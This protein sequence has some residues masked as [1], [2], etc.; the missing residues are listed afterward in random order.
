MRYI[1]KKL[2]S[3]SKL[4]S[5]DDP[6]V[7]KHGTVKHRQL[8][9]PAYRSDWTADSFL[10]ETGSKEVVGKTF[11]LNGLRVVF[12]VV[13]VLLLFLLIRVAWLQIVRGDYYYDL[14]EGNRIRISNLEP[15]RGI[16]YD[17]NLNPL[18]RNSA[19]FLLYLMP[20]DLPTN[21]LDRDQIIRDVSKI[22]EGQEKDSDSP[23]FMLI[24]ESLDKISIKSLEM[25]QPMFVADN[26][27]YEIAMKLYL[28][29]E[30]TPGMVLATKTRR[31][32]FW[33]DEVNISEPHL[34]IS[35]SH[36]LGYT[37]KI[38][39]EELKEYGNEYSSIDYIGKT[40]IEDFWESALKGIKGK[41]HVEVDALG[42]EKKVISKYP[43]QDGYSLVLSLDLELQQK[44]E[45]VLRR[46]LDGL[47]L[48]KG[49]V[50][51]LDPNTGEVL[52]LV[53]W[54]AYDNNIFARGIKVN[55]YQALLEDENNP[56]F[57]RAVS[58]E[59][60]S[61]ST[62][63]PVFAA[64]ALEEG[65]ISENTTFISNGG[66]RVSQWFFPDW[67]AGGHGLTNVRK[68]LSESVNTFFYYI[69]GGYGDFEGLGLD[70]LVDYAKLFGLGSQTG[71]D[72]N[73]EAKGLVPTREWK[74]EVKDEPWY[75]GDTY[76]FAIGQGD[77][78][79]T[80]LQVANFTTVFANGGKLMRPH[81]VTQIFQE[82]NDELIQEIQPDIVREGFI[83]DYA[84][85]VIK[86]GMRQ[87]VTHGSARALGWL[88][89]KVAGKTGT[90]QWSSKNNN[91]AWF[92]GFAPYDEPEVVIT[93]LV[94]EGGEGSAVAVPIAGEI[95]N[96]YFTR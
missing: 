57:N 3:G 47:K 39:L 35:L 66:V 30:Q 27:D 22:L 18:V 60:P 65:I 53:S 48:N 91:H 81:L 52:T 40:G 96:W 50:I 10:S 76:H 34:G 19:N 74:Q 29:S 12:L 9:D 77:L 69:G 78:L 37:G 15:N 82:N 49:S 46:H 58:G 33:P 6:F 61:G 24:K 28:K 79:A 13:L 84:L 56:L 85:L 2:F 5:S 70:K 94:E 23:W 36:L 20:V 67:K 75:I 42:K 93:V 92:T 17:R 32:Y 68:A 4:S 54:P 87:A 63:K 11:E 26:L 72:L 55:E 8:K 51:I 16:I 45:E 64:A 14:A 43:S 83:N 7:V 71:L 1:F 89:V 80:P 21:E 25:Y 44:T 62:V 38:S 90:A 73:V 31:E 41:K 88:P 95:L 59:F 86:Q